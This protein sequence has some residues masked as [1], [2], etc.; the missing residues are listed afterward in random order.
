M[1]NKHKRD[2][3]KEMVNSVY[4]LKKIIESGDIE[5]FGPL[6]DKNWK[7]KTQMASGISNPEID[8]WYNI[9]ISS[10]AKGG[11]ILG[12]GNGGFLMFFAP[13]EHHEAICKSLKALR[14]IPVALDN[15]GSIITHYQQPNM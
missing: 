14:E 13:K 10:G 1:S 11:K 12:A 9:G 2:L 3:M 4:D 5:S 7:I 15:R 6:L 8:E